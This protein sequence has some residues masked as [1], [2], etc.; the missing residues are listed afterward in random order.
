[1]RNRMI[2]GNWK[3]NK[4]YSEAVTLATEICDKL[5]SGN[6]VDVVVCP[7]AVDLKGVAEVLEQK[8]APVWLGAQNVY[9]E[10]SGAYTGETAPDMLT[11]V[12]CKY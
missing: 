12:G 10:E 3:M 4:N 7:P 2:A 9:F 6:G 11:D 8:N 5:G 1:M